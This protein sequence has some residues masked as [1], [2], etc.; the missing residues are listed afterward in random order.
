MVI[1]KDLGDGNGAHF[2]SLFCAAGPGVPQAWVS[3][4]HSSLS[5]PP[6][7]AD[8]KGRRAGLPQLTPSVQLLPACCLPFGPAAMDGRGARVRAA[9]LGLWHLHRDVA[10][11]L[12][13][14]VV[15]GQAG[16]G[17]F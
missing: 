4:P 8:R 16:V 11:G 10:V 1:L 6:L 14:W 12:C 2:S 9:K 13:V 3:T 5:P 17:A 7:C 15:G